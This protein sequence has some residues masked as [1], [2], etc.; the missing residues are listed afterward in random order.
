MARQLLQ[1]QAVGG[2]NKDN[3]FSFKILE[4]LSATGL[5]SIRYAKE[6]PYAT[7]IIANDF[8]ESAII[9]MKRNIE[10]NKLENLIQISYSNAMYV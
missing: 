2:D 5:R 7:E 3:K 10:H 1:K 9:N 8:S 6:V 4:A